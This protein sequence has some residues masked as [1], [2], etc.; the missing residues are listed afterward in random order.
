MKECILIIALI[1]FATACSQQSS[2]HAHDANDPEAK[3]HRDAQTQIEKRL[4]RIDRELET[5]EAHARD[6][7]GVAKLKARNHYYDQMADIEKLRT[8]TRQ[9]FEELRRASG[10]QWEPAHNDAESATEK[11]ERAWDSVRQQIKEGT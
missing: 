1:L 9:K 6:D 3:Q 8:D 5:L 2:V 10:E 7:K 11:L 4:R